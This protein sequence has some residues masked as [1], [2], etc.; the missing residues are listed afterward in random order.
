[1]DFGSVVI[2]NSVVKK[3][4]WGVGHLITTLKTKPTREEFTSASCH[5]DVS[6]ETGTSSVH[7]PLFHKAIIGISQ[8]WQCQTL[9][10][11]K[12]YNASA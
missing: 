7:F 8:R 6:V 10:T 11:P 3:I 9:I 4:K 5:S 12:C 2:A 1:M